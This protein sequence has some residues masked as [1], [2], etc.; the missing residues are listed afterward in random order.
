MKA[1]P[2]CGGPSHQ[3]VPQTMY[4]MK[5][6]TNPNDAIVNGTLRPGDWQTNAKQKHH[7]QTQMQG[8]CGLRKRSKEIIHIDPKQMLQ[9]NNVMR[10]PVNGTCQ[11]GPIP[12]GCTCSK[13]EAITNEIT[14]SKGE[15]KKCTLLR[16][17]LHS[18]MC[19]FNVN[20][21]THPGVR[22]DVRWSTRCYIFNPRI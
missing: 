22:G 1:A 10:E 6:S 2:E 21:C 11:P 20:R 5:F 3:G 17:N 15:C 12:G 13:I 8:C 7:P 18:A 16:C 14:A 9:E 4:R 19:F